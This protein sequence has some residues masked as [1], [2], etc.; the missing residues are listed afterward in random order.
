MAD[1]SPVRTDSGSGRR[2][3]LLRVLGEG[4]FGSVYLAEM[5]GAGGFKRRV[6]L[7]LLN[8]AWDPASDAGRRLRDEARILGRM[9]HANIVRVDDLVRVNG[10]WALVMEYVSG[11]DVET[12]FGWA[13]QHAQPIPPRAAL[14]ICASVAA[15]LLAAWDAPGDDGEPLH[16]VHRDI[17]PSNV[18]LTDTGA[19][20]VLDFGVARAEFA[21]REARTERIR[22]GSLGYMAPERILGGP[23]AAAGDVYAVGVM[24]YEL[25][26][27]RTLGRAELGFERQVAQVDA[28]RDALEAVVGDGPLVVLLVRALAYT[29]EDRPTVGELAD[30]LRGFAAALSGEDLATYA[31]RVLP[32]LA[33]TRTTDSSVLGTVLEEASTGTTALDAAARVASAT[34]VVDT[35]GP[36][37]F[38]S[39]G[40]VVLPEPEPPARRGLVYGVALVTALLVLGIGWVVWPA[41][42]VVPAVVAPTTS[43]PP[44]P[45]V[46]ASTPAPA[47]APT[48]EL[49]LSTTA[50]ASAEPAAPAGTPPSALPAPRSP[51]AEAGRTP[52]VP[53]A[54][55]AAPVPEAATPAPA[56]IPSPASSG[57]RLRSAKFTLAGA[58]GIRVTCGDVSGNGETSALLRNFPSG[59]C[60]VSAAGSTTTVRLDAPRGVDCAVEGDS[61]TCR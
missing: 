17:K 23:D 34:L 45:P 3:S 47:P 60:T 6:A 36:G 39:T 27:L 18:R 8:D 7:K 50:A 1:T 57:E 54:A 5:E 32:R 12:V 10:R 14:E 20:K 46:A 21:G 58:E 43:V 44:A 33:T 40:T 4:A 31:R 28:A 26:T 25:L 56:A 52:M 55:I 49:A 11:A 51:R 61:L 22:Y 38:G 42:A 29:P 35:L 9:D 16:V 41:P 48:A 19:V 53:K 2:F 24:A 13:E 15:A 37:G 59:D 30:A